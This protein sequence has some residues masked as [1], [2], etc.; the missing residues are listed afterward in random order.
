MAARSTAYCWRMRDQ[1]TEILGGACRDCGQTWGLEFA[2]KEPT[3]CNGRGRGMWQRLKDVRD[4]ISKYTLLCQPCHEA[5]D[6]PA[7]MNPHYK[8]RKK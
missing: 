6:G 2:H 4:N 7:Y 8:K 5:F 1:L 3:E